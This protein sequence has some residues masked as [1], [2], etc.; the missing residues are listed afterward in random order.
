MQQRLLVRVLFG[1]EQRRS[2]TFL[3]LDSLAA[4]T[5]ALFAA[6]LLEGRRVR[7]IMGG[8]V[9]DDGTLLAD[10]LPHGAP[11]PESLTMHAV[12]GPPGSAPVGHGNPNAA[13]GWPTGSH[14]AASA[15]VAASAGTGAGV[16]AAY[17]AAAGDG[18]DAI[19]VGGVKLQPRH[20][21]L[22]ICGGVL[23]ALWYVALALPRYFKGPA[24]AMLLIFSLVYA[25]A[26]KSVCVACLARRGAAGA[27]IG[28]SQHGPHAAAGGGSEP[29]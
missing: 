14:H 3:V 13:T 15:G 16:A 25:A 5:Q 17:A 24:W 11:M 26:A 20:M 2:D 21:L 22:G 27:H 9:R 7:L 19:D 29:R 10:L 23:G 1:A 28:G 18:S 4:V 6:E 8:R 12:I